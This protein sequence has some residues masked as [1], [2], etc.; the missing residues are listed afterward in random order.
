VPEWRYSPPEADAETL[1]AAA[2]LLYL[3]S[4]PLPAVLAGA[5]GLLEHGSSRSREG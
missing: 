2:A 3:A 4:A 1:L 5:G